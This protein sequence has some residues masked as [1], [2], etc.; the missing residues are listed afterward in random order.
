[1]RH[2][3]F[4]WVSRLCIL[5]SILKTQKG[6]EDPWI[7]H[8]RSAA[9]VCLLTCPRGLWMWLL[10]PTDLEPGIMHNC[11]DVS[12]FAAGFLAWDLQVT[13]TMWP[14][15]HWFFCLPWNLERSLF[16]ELNQKEKTCMDRLECV[17]L[18]LF[19]PTRAR[20]EFTR[21]R[22]NDFQHFNTQHA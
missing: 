12:N 15:N 21:A 10:I 11:D 5:Q 2:L 9:Q 8:G 1:M 22:K 7:H 20:V 14:D 17:L 6:N 13:K 16:S 4:V 18:G 3:H 19:R